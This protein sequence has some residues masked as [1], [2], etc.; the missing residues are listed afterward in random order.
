MALAFNPSTLEGI[1]WQISEFEASLIYKSS[2]RT[3]RDIQET[4]VLKNR[5]KAKIAPRRHRFLLLITNSP[6]G[7][8][9]ETIKVT[10]TVGNFKYRK[11]K[12]VYV[13]SI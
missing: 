3:S 5:N 13:F 10:C 6:F 4:P 2:S 11:V 12:R 1:G 9:L 7:N 8:V